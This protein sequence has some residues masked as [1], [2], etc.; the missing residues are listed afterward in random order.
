L[1]SNK[2]NK[3]ANLTPKEEELS[4][5]FELKSLKDERQKKKHDTIN[6]IF[7]NSKFVDSYCFKIPHKVNIF[8]YSLLLFY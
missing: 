4:K 5:R 3:T 6:S 7:L 1:F 2:F 8:I